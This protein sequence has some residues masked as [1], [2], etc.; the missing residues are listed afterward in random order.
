MVAL[1][2]VYNQFISF[3]EDNSEDAHLA[4]KIAEVKTCP[5]WRGSY[6]AIDGSTVEL[7]TKPGYYGKVFFDRKSNYSLGCQVMCS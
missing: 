3:L 5:E 4:H 1:L 7:F 2:K 6:L